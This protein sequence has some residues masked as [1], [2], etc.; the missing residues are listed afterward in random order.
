M[1]KVENVCTQNLKLSAHEL[2]YILNSRGNG[3]HAGCRTFRILHPAL[4][5]CTQGVWVWHISH[6]PYKVNVD[7]GHQKREDRS[8][9]PL[10]ST[11]RGLWL[12]GTWRKGLG[13]IM[14]GG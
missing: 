1:Q 5:Q 3:A 12:L 2:R 13:N 11:F 4:N 6:L 14:G 9:E 7:K 10:E 8:V